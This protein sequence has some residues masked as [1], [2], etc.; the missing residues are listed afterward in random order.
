MLQRSTSAVVFEVRLRLA[1]LDDLSVD[2]LRKNF[3]YPIR[4]IDVQIGRNECAEVRRPR[5]PG[6]AC[7]ANFLE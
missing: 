2:V 5:E 1:E 3:R 6:I 7:R 4:R